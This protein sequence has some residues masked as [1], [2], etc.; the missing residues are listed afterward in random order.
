MA[1]KFG[2][3]GLR[4]LST[5]LVGSVSALYA[6]AF[7]RFLIESDHLPAGGVIAVARDFR[8]SSPEIAATVM[9]AIRRAGLVPVDCGWIPTPALALYA[10]KIGA[11]GI[12][13]TGSH[14]P[15]DRNGI[16]FYRPDGEID[17]DD[18]ATITR[19]AAALENDQ[20]ANRVERGMVKTRKPKQRNCFSI[21]I[22]PY[23]L[24]VPLRGFESAST[25]TAA[26]PAT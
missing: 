5:E 18:E 7:A 6:I 9:A 14:I 25:S 3:S 13:V 12:M 2:T 19:L 16:K 4:G 22:S 26:S 1:V 21:V 23:C 8:E 15:A 10:Q 17:K 24:L 11:A 20:A